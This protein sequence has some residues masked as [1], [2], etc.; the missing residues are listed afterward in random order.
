MKLHEKHLFWPA[1]LT[2]LSSIALLACLLFTSPLKNVSFIALFF[3]IFLA[4][5]INLGHLIVH[6]RFG[7]VKMQHRYRIFVFSI[8]ILLVVMFR[9]AQSLNP[10]DI[11]ILILIIVGLFFY[12]AK[13]VN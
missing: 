7:E 6:I 1:L 9:S 11:S 13:R 4:F 12:G 3:V 2:G 8:F 10:V 5:L